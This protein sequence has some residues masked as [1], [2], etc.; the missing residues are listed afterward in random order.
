M[1]LNDFPAAV[2]TC[3]EPVGKKIWDFIFGGDAD[4]LL[5]RLYIEAEQLDDLGRLLLE[6]EK[7]VLNSRSKLWLFTSAD[8]IKV[9]GE[10]RTQS[11]RKLIA[12]ARLQIPEPWPANLPRPNPGSLPKTLPK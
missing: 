6:V 11:V 3:L 5:V 12:E 1:H 2:R 4:K 8:R 10:L 7:S 9:V